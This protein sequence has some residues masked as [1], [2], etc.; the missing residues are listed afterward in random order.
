[1]AWGGKERGELPM[2]DPYVLM[3]GGKTLGHPCA[4]KKGKKKS[5]ITPIYN[6]DGKGVK[7]SPLRVT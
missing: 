2:P 6:S 4:R 1:M 5:S 7:P 3:E